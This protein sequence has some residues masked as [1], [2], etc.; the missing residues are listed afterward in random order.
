MEGDH[1]S[2]GRQPDDHGKCLRGGFVSENNFRHLKL[3]PMRDYQADVNDDETGKDDQPD[4][5]ETARRL[6][7]A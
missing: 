1:G 2:Y 6:P 7:A 3:E 4:K 5:V